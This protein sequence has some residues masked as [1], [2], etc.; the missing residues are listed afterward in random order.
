EVIDL[1]LSH[2]DKFGN[3]SSHH[4]A[5]EEARELVD[6]ARVQVASLVNAAPE[7][8]IF[9]GSGSEADNLAIKGVAFA[10]LSK[11]KDGKPRGFCPLSRAVFNTWDRFVARFRVP[12][13]I[14]TSQIEHSAVLASCRFLEELG[15][16]VSYLPVSSGGRVDPDDVRRRL[17]PNT[18][19]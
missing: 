19:L 14:I 4:W 17:R 11:G 6:R 8:I 9:T 7:E 3:P 2:M 12:V 15:H 13:H 16:R 1:I 10:P 18:R 5:G